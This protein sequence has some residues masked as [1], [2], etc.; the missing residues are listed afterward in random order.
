MNRY[1]PFPLPENFLS[2]NTVK[3][4]ISFLN[5]ITP[6]KN[7]CKNSG[8]NYGGEDYCGVVRIQRYRIKMTR[9]SLAIK[10]ERNIKPGYFA[11]HTCDNRCCINPDHLYEGTHMD[12]V[13][14]MT[15]RKL[16]PIDLPPSWMWL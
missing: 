13:R 14:D 2:L 16:P 12:N 15:A 3:E 9:L 10:L 7:G 11:C 1:A 4:Y 5:S 6:D 8:G